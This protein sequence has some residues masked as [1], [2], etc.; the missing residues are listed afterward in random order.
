[1]TNL[2]RAKFDSLRQSTE[3]AQERLA[4]AKA[5]SVVSAR[6]VANREL[7]L[8]AHAD[9]RENVRRFGMPYAAAFKNCLSGRRA[10][11][12]GYTG[13]FVR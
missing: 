12:N 11:A 3:R 9:A 5:S 8:L 6:Q 4:V 2:H 7:F 1:M 10:V 13:S